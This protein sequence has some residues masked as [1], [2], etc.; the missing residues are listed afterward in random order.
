MDNLK[1]CWSCVLK[2]RANL[3]AL[4][5]L[6]IIGMWLAGSCTDVQA[7]RSSSEIAPGDTIEVI[8]E[9][10]WEAERVLLAS[11][12]VKDTLVK[13][14]ASVKQTATLRGDIDGEK[15]SYNFSPTMYLR[16]RL[17]KARIDVAS[18][19]K[20]PVTLSSRRVVSRTP[21]R[22][23]NTLGEDV[24][25]ELTFS[26][27]QV[28]T[29][30]YGNSFTAV[31]NGSDT[32]AVP[33]LE[34]ES[35]TFEK[36]EIESFGNK[37]ETEDPYKATLVLEA[38][39]K[40]EGVSA[41]AEIADN[42]KLS[43]WY[44]KVVTEE[45]TEVTGVEYSGKYVGCPY[46]AYELTE[47]VTTNKGEETHTYTVD[48]ALDVKAPAEREQPSRD[49]LF[50]Q[51]STGSLSE[52]V[53]SEVTTGDGFT[54]QTLSGTYV[55]SNT[56]TESGTVV[57]STI[58][59]TYQ[60]PVHFES[61]YGSYDI[62]DIG[63][64]FTELAFDVTKISDSDGEKTFRSV[65]SLY[66]EIAGCTLDVIDENVL[67][68][69]SNEPEGL[70]KKDSIYTLTGKDDDYVVDKEIIW[71]DG[72]STHSSYSYEGRHSATAVAFGE[73]VT[74]SLEWN[75][76]QLRQ[77]STFEETEEKKFSQTTKF[78]AT[79]TTTS[80]QSATTNGRES[81][82]FAFRT[83]SPKVVFTDGNVVKTFPERTY[84][85]TGQGADVAPNY[86]TLVRNGVTYKAYPYD[87]TARAVWNGGNPAS[88]VSAGY[89]LVAADEEGEPTYTTNQTWNGATTT[90]TVV[91]T[92]PHSNGEDE[93]ET[94][95][96]PFTVTLGELTDGKLYAD[97]TE[98]STT[99]SH[100][101][102]SSSAVDGYWT[103]KIYAATY[104]YVTGNGVV[105]RRQEIDVR[106]AEIIFDDGT[107]SHTFDVRLAMSKSETLQAD[108]VR[109]EGD[110]VVTPHLLTVTGK[111]ADG[112]SFSTDG[113]TDIYVKKEDV[114]V[115][116]SAKKTVVYADGT[117]DFVLEK[118]M[119][120]GTTETVRSSETFGARFAFD[121]ANTAA[122]TRNVSNVDYSAAGTAGAA[123]TSSHNRG[124]W[125]VMEY[126]YPYTH[127][128]SNGV[129]ADRID[130]PYSYS[131][132][133]ATLDDADLGT[134]SFDMPVVSLTPKNLQISLR[135][136]NSGYDEYNAAVTVAGSARGT[137]GAYNADLQV[138]HILRMEGGEE[139]D[140]PHFGKP[141]GFYVTATLDPSAKVTRRAFLFQWERG[142]TYAVCDYETM[143]PSSGDFMYQADTYQGYN[144][145]GFDADTNSW[146]PARGVDTA[147]TLEWY[148]SDGRLMSALSDFECM[149]YGWKNVVN[150]QYA[151]EISG[152]TYVTDGYQIT[153]TAPN[154]ETVT[155]DSHYER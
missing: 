52:E 36:V 44:R 30:F 71:S 2:K 56:G 28:A 29:V 117:V 136:E 79:Y 55:S 39:Y 100:S 113:I 125:Q 61:E 140:D 134:V 122:Q 64:K 118:Q 124:S 58:S 88:L 85:I 126:R 92:T 151:L 67:L 98:F 96:K 139:P 38:A 101:S 1:K 70:A 106:D 87:Y 14:D 81:G 26:D 75:E 137:E 23:G 129:T 77:A 99:E 97:N 34:I 6:C 66:G 132:F 143:L 95:T 89:L 63:L 24:V 46:T 112:K 40:A 119:S 130:S 115:S 108:D 94:F 69:V 133:S 141:K 22:N 135:G 155:F 10:Y 121:F 144:A 123:T 147:N 3:A 78:T 49:S 104:R 25:E 109:T 90:V 154:G 8:T 19:D 45:A 72:S 65:N 120:D 41:G 33:H 93:T 153:V 114:T 43:P 60:K 68:K 48:L 128:L 15:F 27:G 138:T 42:V 76:G 131:N 152:Y 7:E 82:T 74:T 50:N 59:F 146:L 149:T 107:F 12:T 111:T 86:T 110:Y 21:Y 5:L 83:T 102:S 91:K 47:K 103:V 142:V 150:G 18:A 4:L 35:I 37:T 31:I 62:P 127:T 32:L 145:V 17:A 51:V 80:W 9:H 54:V 105:E 16:V 53:L 84:A 57:E 148:F 13:S 116:G 73:K 11:V 20:L